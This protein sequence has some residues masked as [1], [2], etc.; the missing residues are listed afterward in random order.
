MSAESPVWR[1]MRDEDLTAVMR[2]AARVHPALPEAEA[3]FAERVRLFPAG[4]LV[5]DGAG[6]VSGYAVSHPSMRFAPPPL[7]TLLGALPEAPD[8][9]YLHDFVLAPE[10]RGAG[11]AQRGVEILLGEA[12]AYP[13]TSLVSVYGTGGFWSRFGF[14][15]AIRGGLQAKLAP[16]GQDAVYMLRENR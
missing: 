12:A 15:P 4:C 16:Y 10:T 2:L 7:D 9:Y 1:I 5:L 3:V 11:H 14:R 6:T 8:D 13:S